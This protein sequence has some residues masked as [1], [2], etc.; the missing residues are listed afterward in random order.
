MSVFPYENIQLN[1]LK[2]VHEFG[3][4]AITKWFGLGSL[5]MELYFLTF[6]EAASPRCWQVF[7]SLG[8]SLLGLQVAAS[9]C[10]LTWSFLCFIPGVFSFHDKYTSHMELGSF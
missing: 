2:T 1:I 6:L 10:A 5:T 7:A 3:R 9:C 8:T 4:A